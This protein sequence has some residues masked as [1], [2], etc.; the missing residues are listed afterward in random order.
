MFFR[1][2]TNKTRSKGIFGAVVIKWLL[3]INVIYGYYVIALLLKNYK[4]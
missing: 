1:S 3:M 2:Y 4:Q